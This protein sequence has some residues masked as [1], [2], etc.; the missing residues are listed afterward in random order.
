MLKPIYETADQIPENL[1]EYYTDN[2]DGGFILSVTPD[3]GYALENIN[4]LKSTL[5]KL[6]ERAATAETGLKQYSS[7][8]LSAA[9][10]AEAVEELNSLKMSQGE[11]SEAIQRMKQE[12]ENIKRSARENT[13]KAVAPVQTLADS[14]MEQIKEL[15]IDSKLQTAIVNAGGNP[16]LLMPILKNEVNAKTDENGKV[17]VEIVDADGTPRVTGKDLTPMGFDE[18]VAERKN[19]AELAVAFKANGQSGGGTTPDSTT[20]QSNT[21]REYTPE[22]VASMTLN[23]YRKAREQ[24][25]IPA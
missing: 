7:L 3:G 21:T 1:K 13:E 17:I 24:G 18:L 9:D 10:V 19:D 25:L 4:G 12:L 14:R 20:S 2:E 5:G 16:R 8:G 23:E 11:E 22:E 6:K 15:L